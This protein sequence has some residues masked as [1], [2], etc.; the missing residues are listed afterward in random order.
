MRTA[1][2][3]VF[4]GSC[5]S[6]AGFLIKVERVPRRQSFDDIRLL[7]MRWILRWAGIEYA[8]AGLTGVGE[9]ELN[10]R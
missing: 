9:N 1:L 3:P 7:L 5:V 4:P 10:A 6:N 8:T 2:A